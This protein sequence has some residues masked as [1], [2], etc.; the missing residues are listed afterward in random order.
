MIRTSFAALCLALISG[1]PA[2]A[3]DLFNAD[4]KWLGEG[5][6]STGVRAPLERG[7]CQVEVAPSEGVDAAA[8]GDVNVIGFCAVAAGK[9]DISLRLVRYGDGGVNAGFWSAATGQ[10]IQLA[11]QETPEQIE[12][13]STTALIVDDEPFE[14]QVRVIAPDEDSFQIRQ[15]MRAE[16]EEKWRLVAEMTYHRVDG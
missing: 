8:G 11:G 1:A 6:M 10:T 12:M 14:T 4:G 15:I 16:G 7:R 5:Q 2:Y 9:S 13:I 3:A